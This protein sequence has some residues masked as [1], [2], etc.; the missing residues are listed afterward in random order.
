[1]LLAA[2]GV[3]YSVLFSLI[4]FCSV[5]FGFCQKKNAYLCIEKIQRLVRD[6][7]QAFEN[8]QRS[9]RDVGQAS[10]NLQRS[11]RDVGQAFVRES[12]T[13]KQT[14]HPDP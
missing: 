2:L 12:L 14:S 1:M 7:G 13:I 4:R 8:F 5:L 10:E 6:V 11:A 9:V 3:S